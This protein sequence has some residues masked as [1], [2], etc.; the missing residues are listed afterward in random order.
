MCLCKGC[1]DGVEVNYYSYR[2]LAAYKTKRHDENV[3]SIFVRPFSW[4]P[5]SWW[6]LHRFVSEPKIHNGKTVTNDMVSSAKC[7]H[8]TLSPRRYDACRFWFVLHGDVDGGLEAL[9]EKSFAFKT[10][11]KWRGFRLRC[12][13]PF[14]NY[15]DMNR[16]WNTRSSVRRVDVDGLVRCPCYFQTL[17][18]NVFWQDKTVD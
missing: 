11:S 6:R 10:L 13:S 3:Y 5:A 16:C 15:T 1:N 7:S 12:T 18:D 17:R 14:F 8:T 2:L 9:N 4:V